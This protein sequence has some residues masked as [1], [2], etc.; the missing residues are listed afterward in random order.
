[1]TEKPQMISTWSI[2]KVFI[3]IV[4]LIVTFYALDSLI[5]RKIKKSITD[6]TYTKEI[7]SQVRPFALFNANGTILIDMGAMQ[8]LNDLRVIP[9]DDSRIPKKIL[10]SPKRY[11]AHA[12]MITGI[13]Q[14]GT[15]ARPKRL[16]GLDW[17]YTFDLSYVIERE[18]SPD[19]DIKSK[20]EQ[21]RYRIEIIK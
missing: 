6:P 15:V 13:D 3:I 21:D 2:V 7:A 9:S 8:Y 11:M 12:P 16:A 19:V 1:M 5:E 14:P 17:E 18:T 10:L 20:R 4:G